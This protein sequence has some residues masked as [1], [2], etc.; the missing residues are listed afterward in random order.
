MHT[1]IAFSYYIDISKLRKANS[2]EDSFGV[3]HSQKHS[4]SKPILIQYKQI[5]TIVTIGPS[6]Y[7]LHFRKIL[8]PICQSHYSVPKLDSSSLSLYFLFISYR[9]LSRTESECYGKK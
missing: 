2:F 1:Q 8:Y 6:M 5:A 4:N 3:P 9:S 7:K